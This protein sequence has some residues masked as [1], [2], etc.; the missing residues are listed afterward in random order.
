MSINLVFVNLI[1][2]ALVIISL[3]KIFSS[4][5]QSRTGFVVFYIIFGLLCLFTLLYRLI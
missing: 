4:R 3:F 5:K 2:C 1:L